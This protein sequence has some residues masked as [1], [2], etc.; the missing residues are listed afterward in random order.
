MSMPA[1]DPSLPRPNHLD[2]YQIQKWDRLV[3][4]LRALNAQ[5]EYISLMLR[6]GSRKPG[7]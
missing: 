4:E 2:P 7:P 1:P 3:E 6:L 5:L